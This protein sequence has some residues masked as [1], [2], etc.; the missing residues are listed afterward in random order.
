MGFI[1]G[2]R[3]MFDSFRDYKY[4]TRTERDYSVP[5][6]NVDAPA[7]DQ[8]EVISIVVLVPDKL[9]LDFDNHEVMSVELTNDPGLPVLCKCRQLVGKVYGFHECQARPR[10][11]DIIASR[12]RRIAIAITSR[13]QILPSSS[14]VLP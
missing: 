9:T 13:W 12:E 2:D 3:A 6:L 8:K 11:M 14:I 10:P 7:E 5:K 1:F 4:F